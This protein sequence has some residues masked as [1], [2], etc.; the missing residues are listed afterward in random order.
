MLYKLFNIIDFIY[1]ISYRRYMRMNILIDY[2][3]QEA[4]ARNEYRRRR[5]EFRKKYTEIDKILLQLIQ[6]RVFLNNTRKN[7]RC[8]KILSFSIVSILPDG[9]QSGKDRARL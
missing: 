5:L 6:V 4:E 1:M 7:H 9:M 2:E 3:Q 8:S